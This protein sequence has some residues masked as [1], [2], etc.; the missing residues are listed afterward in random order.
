MPSAT[1]NLAQDYLSLSDY[2]NAEKY[3]RETIS[4]YPQHRMGLFRME[5][6]VILGRGEIALAKGDY[7]QAL[8]CAEEALIMY[9]KADAKKYIARGL[10]LKA[11]AL[12]G[13]GRMDEATG[14]MEEALKLAQ[15]I[16]N[17]PTLWQIHHGFG[18]LF[19]RR[20]D[21]Q[22]ASRHHAAAIALIEATASK[23]NDSSVKNTL[24]TSAQTNTIYDAYT[25][26][27]SAL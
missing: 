23:L 1:L 20:G 15:Q 14:L 12:A 10:K 16:G 22:K 17:P 24:L 4:L 6:K 9:E 8:K 18:L 25:R 13:M 27:K 5:G 2:E 26:T 19:E 3:F 11:E 7:A 21:L